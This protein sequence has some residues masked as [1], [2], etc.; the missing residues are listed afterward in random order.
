[1]LQTITIS[2]KRQITIPSSLFEKLG[3]KQGDKMIVEQT[4]D[5]IQLTP[6]EKVVED[7]AGSVRM[8]KRFAQKNIDEIIKIA[9]DEYFSKK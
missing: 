4:D 9:R 2:T 3:L 6:A 1:M 8:P 5:S 7:L